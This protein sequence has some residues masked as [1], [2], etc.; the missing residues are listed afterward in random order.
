MNASISASRHGATSRSTLSSEANKF[1]SVS[2][3][4]PF[5]ISAIT[6]ARFAALLFII[7]PGFYEKAPRIASVD[8]RDSLSRR[9]THSTLGA[10][11]ED[12]VNGVLL[13]ASISAPTAE[14]KAKAQTQKPRRRRLR[15]VVG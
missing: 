1:S 9:T 11:R 2:K 5:N 14:Y 6:N 15:S 3:S 10:S 8:V 7:S 13:V 12:A 4:P